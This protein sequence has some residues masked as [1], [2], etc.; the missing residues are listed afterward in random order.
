[1]TFSAS[2]A[3]CPPEILKEVFTFACD[4]DDGSTGRALS[5]V[6]RYIHEVSEDLKYRSLAVHGVKQLFNCS[7]LLEAKP[8]PL[9]R[10]HHLFIASAKHHHQR[11]A[12]NDPADTLVESYRSENK[13]DHDHVRQ[14]PRI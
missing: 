6:S 2:L 12:S 8:P 9:R 4:G 1:M 3:H 11:L 14:P 13:I 10:I 5:L 7:V